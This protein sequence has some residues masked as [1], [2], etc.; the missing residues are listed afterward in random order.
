MTQPLSGKVAVVT[1]AG[2][3]I[4]RAI[5]RVLAQDGAQLMLNAR[6]LKDLETLKAEIHQ[7]IDKHREVAVCRA[8]VSDF[9]ECNR[10][11][12]ETMRHFGRVDIL[13]NN[14]AVAP[15]FGLLHELSAADIDQTI[16]VNLKAPI[17]MMKF[18]LPLMI[19]QGEGWIVNINSTAGKIAYPYSSVY[20]A[21]KFG[22]K[23]VT[24]CVD[25]EQKQNRIRVIGIYPGEVH[26]SMWD[27]LEPGVTQDPNRML[28]PEDVAQ[29]VRY[30]LTQPT[31][32]FVKDV[33][34]VPTFGTPH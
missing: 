3:G 17:Y 29:A 20:C 1:G 19:H 23:A 22:L 12:E 11:V 7:E 32:A 18:V 26:T 9:A 31:R 30:V 25:A 27:A 14:A 15:A 16:D 6:T 8:D 5:A 24:E 4:G 34:L 10:L 33:T 2:K 21:T 13:I 28:A